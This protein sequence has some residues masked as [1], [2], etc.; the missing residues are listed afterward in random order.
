[1][2]D[3]NNMDVIQENSTLRRAGR[4]VPP[5]L[6]PDGKPVLRSAQEQKNRGAL[7]GEPAGSAF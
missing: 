3:V 2:R 7:S 6:G 5:K 4:L 1:V